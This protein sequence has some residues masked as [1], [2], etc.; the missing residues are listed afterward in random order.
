[1]APTKGEVHNRAG[2]LGLAE[3]VLAK[4]DRSRQ[5]EARQGTPGEQTVAGAAAE[6]RAVE[7]RHHSVA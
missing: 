3:A 5:R 2:G 4:A 1:M 7:M 6:I